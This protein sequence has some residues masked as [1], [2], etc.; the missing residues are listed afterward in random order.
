MA[1]S[2]PSPVRGP[3]PP[4]AV[5][6]GAVAPPALGGALGLGVLLVTLALTPLFFGTMTLGAFEYPKVAL[7]SLAMVLLLALGLSALLRPRAAAPA[8]PRP[9]AGRRLLGLWRQPLLLGAVLMLLSAVA[10][11]VASI[12]PVTSVI[13]TH[14]SHAGLVTTL[15]YAVLFLAAR[16]LCRGH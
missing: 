7:L 13:G 9:S 12:S 4:A 8:A 3:R 15:A 5:R 1:D 16:G 2:K 14:E 10:S 6:A 11:T